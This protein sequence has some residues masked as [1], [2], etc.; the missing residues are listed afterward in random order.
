MFSTNQKLTHKLTKT[1]N[2]T[3]WLAFW[4]I[5]WFIFWLD[6]LLYRERIPSLEELT[7]RFEST[8]DKIQDS[9][10]MIEANMGDNEEFSFNMT[11]KIYNLG[12]ADISS[13]DNAVDHYIKVLE[14]Y[15]RVLDYEKSRRQL[16]DRIKKTSEIEAMKEGLKKNRQQRKLASDPYRKRF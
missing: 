2:L 11:R 13:M 8:C 7:T 12:S 10:L 9:I 5:F 16:E 14:E 15:K 6:I 3:N 1:K 4:F